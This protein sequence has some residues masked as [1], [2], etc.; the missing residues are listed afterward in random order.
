[1]RRRHIEHVALSKED[2]LRRHTV[3]LLILFAE[4]DGLV[5]DIYP[6]DMDPLHLRRNTQRDAA[7]PG[8]YINHSQHTTTTTTTI[9]I[10]LLQA[11][12]QLATPFLGLPSR[13][14]HPWAALHLDFTE[15]LRP[16]HVL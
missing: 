16:N 5:T 12:Y 8:T 13:D 10:E 15:R 1:V 7:C 4:G 3:V 11:S 14:Q 6:S 9:T 2:S